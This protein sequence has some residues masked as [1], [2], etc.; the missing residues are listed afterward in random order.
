VPEHRNGGVSEGE[1]SESWW[2]WS[3]K[4]PV[5]WRGTNSWGMLFELTVYHVLW[6]SYGML[7]FDAATTKRDFAAG[8]PASTSGTSPTGTDTTGVSRRV[9]L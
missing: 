9:T 3:W 2:G 7:N 5:G 1:G 8:D 4:L 6:P